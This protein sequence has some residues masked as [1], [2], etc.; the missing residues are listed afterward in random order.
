MCS[1][2]IVYQQLSMSRHL[3]EDQL[4]E[5][6]EAFQL[7]DKESTGAIRSQEVGS[8]KQALAGAS[9]E[10]CENIHEIQLKTSANN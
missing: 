9:S 2:Y 7:V 10:Y 5:A 8:L 6:R 3:S 4:R 1:R